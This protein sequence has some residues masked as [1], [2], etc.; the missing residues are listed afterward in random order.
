MT[1]VPIVIE[2]V[3]ISV[4]C[5]SLKLYYVVKIIGYWEH[6]TNASPERFNPLLK[7]IFFI[8]S[9]ITRRK[10][11]LLIVLRRYFT[12]YIL[13][14]SSLWNLFYGRIGSSYN[15]KTNKKDPFTLCV[16]PSFLLRLVFIWLHFDK[17]FNSKILY[18]DLPKCRFFLESFLPLS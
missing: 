8:P 9:L 15:D 4:G 7:S 5:I 14:I 10:L 18:F 17:V 11:S 13:V 16:F 2:T 12:T 1:R 6:I 3:R